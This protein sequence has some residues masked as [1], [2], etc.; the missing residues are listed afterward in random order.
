[1]P[2]KHKKF[3][4]R[5]LPTQ[6]PDSRDDQQQVGVVK[7][8]LGDCRFEIVLK[9]DTV[10]IGH[11]RGAI[12]KRCRVMAD[13]IV[14]VAMRPDFTDDSKVDIIHVYSPLALPELKRRGLLKA[15]TAEE[16]CVFEFTS[17]VDI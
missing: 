14:L 12:K 7:S 16:E 13:S 1:M 5:E 3:K 9:D 2:A 10:K 15:P 17:I 4:R 8:V 11:V 6:F